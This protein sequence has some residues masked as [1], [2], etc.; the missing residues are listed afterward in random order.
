MDERVAFYFIYET[1]FPLSYG[2]SSVELS[3]YFWMDFKFDAGL[4]LN[5][6]K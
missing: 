5:D 1:L 6:R 4:Y 2:L 3:L